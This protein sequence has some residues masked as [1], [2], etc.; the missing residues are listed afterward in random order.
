MSINFG[1][2]EY[3]KFTIIV[4]VL[5]SVSSELLTSISSH[6]LIPLIDTDCNKDGKPDIQNNL[7]NKILLVN[8]KKVIFIG[9]FAYTLIKFILILLFLYLISKIF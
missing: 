3:L 6:I 4:T 1:S 9:E 8:K 5:A 7:R 2:K